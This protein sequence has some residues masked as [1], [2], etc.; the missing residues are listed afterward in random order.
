MVY[1]KAS[2]STTNQMLSSCGPKKSF[3]LMD[4][5]QALLTFYLLFEQQFSNDN[6]DVNFHSLFNLSINMRLENTQQKGLQEKNSSG[7]SSGC[8]FEMF[9]Q[10]SNLL[11]L[12]LNNFLNNKKSTN[13]LLLETSLASLCFLC[14]RLQCSLRQDS[15]NNADVVM[16]FSSI[17]ENY[18]SLASIQ[19]R[20]NLLQL[21]KYE[22]KSIGGSPNERSLQL[23]M[24]SSNGREEGHNKV[25]V[26][27]TMNA[28]HST[29]AP[30]WGTSS[31]CSE[32]PEVLSYDFLVD[33]LTTLQDG[34]RYTNSNNSNTNNISFNALLIQLRLEWIGLLVEFMEYLDQ[35]IYTPGN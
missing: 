21:Y 23:L 25:K 22:I 30:L 15:N 33:A 17:F 10:K 16:W 18:K 3:A 27:S 1:S 4:M 7:L 11:I 31:S 13:V 34:Y 26:E 19:A 6:N 28:I 24:S 12:A 14:F 35:N 29:K 2:L 8:L 20:Q 5:L 9:S 32:T